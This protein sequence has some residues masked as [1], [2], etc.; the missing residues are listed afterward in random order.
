MDSSGSD[1]RYR[2]QEATGDELVA[3]RLERYIREYKPDCWKVP[4]GNVA[5][6]PMLDAA[7]A[8]FLA[9]CYRKKR[10]NE[11]M[12]KEPKW[13]WYVRAAITDFFEKGLHEHGLDDAGHGH[14]TDAEPSAG[15]G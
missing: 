7:D 15:T 12:E 10:L 1:A 3:L 5:S 11:A 2:P 6:G 9:G 14:D 4:I 8:E 13:P